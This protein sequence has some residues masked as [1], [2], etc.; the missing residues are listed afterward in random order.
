[1]SSKW[2]RNAFMEETIG[3]DFRLLR[4]LGYLH[5]NGLQT[6]G[7]YADNLNKNQLSNFG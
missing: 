3:S 4:S 6:D 5:R 1:M 7:E 2:Q